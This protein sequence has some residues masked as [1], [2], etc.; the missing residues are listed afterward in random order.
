MSSAESL[1]A[2]WTESIDPASGNAFYCFAATGETTWT[3]PVGATPLDIP[4]PEGWQECVDSASGAPFYTFVATGQT[5]W[6]RP[7]PEA[8]ASTAV[9]LPGAFIAYLKC[10][11]HIIDSIRSFQEQHQHHFDGSENEYSLEA[12]TSYQGFVGM[13]DGYLQPFLNEQ[14]VTAETFAETLGE[15]KHKDSKR[16]HAF[17]LMLDRMDFQVLAQLMRSKTCLCCGGY[18]MGVDLGA[19]H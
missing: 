11:P 18:F 13:I 5:T 2:G 10:N 15:L 4:L 17:K 8:P 16:F 6:E 1:P 12:T 19:E 7:V 9:G 3:R 14:G